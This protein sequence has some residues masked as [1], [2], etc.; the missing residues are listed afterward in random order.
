MTTQP[1]G[2]RTLKSWPEG[3]RAIQL[4]AAKLNPYGG[5]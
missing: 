2:K 1:A 4:A 3:C 5:T